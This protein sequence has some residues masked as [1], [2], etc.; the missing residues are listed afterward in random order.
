MK[1]RGYFYVLNLVKRTLHVSFAICKNF[2]IYFGEKV[3]QRNIRR[4]K[5]KLCGFFFL[6]TGVTIDKKKGF[7]RSVRDDF[8]ILIFSLL[9]K[10]NDEN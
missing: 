5:Y 1:R 6:F 4:K 7:F 8:S 9:G 2:V 3:T 10:L